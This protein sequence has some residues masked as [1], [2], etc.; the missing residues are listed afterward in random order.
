MNKKIK[1]EVEIPEGYDL[2]INGTDCKL[3]PKSK[4][5]KTWEEFCEMNPIEDGEC[6]I[7]ANS[8]IASLK[9]GYGCR[10]RD[11]STDRSLLPNKKTAEAFLALMQ[12]IQL[13]NRYNGDW[14]PDWAND[15]KKWVIVPCRDEVRAFCC[16]SVNRVLV[17]KTEN[18]RNQ[19]LE[20]F[21]DLIEIAKPLI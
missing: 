5:P 4:L 11:A 21:R 14:V 7:L 13:R 15:T 12:L 19:F 16:E 20:N 8:E 3:V 9:Y 2:V 6:V 17:F 18:L 1:V 10:R